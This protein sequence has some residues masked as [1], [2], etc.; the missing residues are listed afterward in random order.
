MN[1]YN[2]ICIIHSEQI[3]NS[4]NTVAVNYFIDGNV[5]LSLVKESS[6]VKSGFHL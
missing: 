5:K 3:E 4:G 6:I 1:I 2:V